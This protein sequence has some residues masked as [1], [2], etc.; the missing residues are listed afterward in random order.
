MKNAEQIATDLNTA[1]VLLSAAY[2]ALQDVR[3]KI[4]PKPDNQYRRWTEEEDVRL[5]SE[6][7]KLLATG[8]HGD[9]LAIELG[10]SLG[11][12]PI[13]V[14]VRLVKVGIWKV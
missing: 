6:A 1:S 12:S 13:A 11:R 2:R 10:Q 14:G 7:G 4:P 9:D 5:I 3:D 8:A